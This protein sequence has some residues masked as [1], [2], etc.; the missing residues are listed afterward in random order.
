VN[1]RSPAECTARYVRKTGFAS[2]ALKARLE[3]LP[4]EPEEAAAAWLLSLTRKAFEDRAVPQPEKC[5]EEP[6]N[7]GIED[8]CLPTSGT[9]Q[10]AALA[11]FRDMAA[12]NARPR[13]ATRS[14]V[15]TLPAP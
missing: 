13:H 7:R 10:G 3:A 9:A 1:A 2:C 8:D 15:P 14:C 6:P 5:L 4:E 12:S 11:F